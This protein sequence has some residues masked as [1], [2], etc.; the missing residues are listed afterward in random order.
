MVRRLLHFVALGALTMTGKRHRPPLQHRVM[1]RPDAPTPLEAQGALAPILLRTA[2]ALVA[3]KEG[4]APSCP[5][6]PIYRSP[7]GRTHPYICARGGSFRTRR[8]PRHS[9]A[10]QRQVVG[11]L[12]QQHPAPATPFQPLQ[13]P[14]S[15]SQSASS[16]PFQSPEPPP[17]AVPLP[18]LY[19]HPQPEAPPPVA[20]P[21]A[22][23][24]LPPAPSAPPPGVPPVPP[25]HPPPQSRTGLAVSTPLPLQ[26]TGP[27]VPLDCALC[28]QHPLVP[29][30][31]LPAAR[32]GF[33]SHSPS[34][35]LPACPVVPIFCSRLP[36]FSNG[37]PRSF[38]PAFPL[39]P[40]HQP[41]PGL[42]RGYLN[43]DEV[44]RTPRDPDV[45]WWAVS[46]PSCP[47]KGVWGQSRPGEAAYRT[48]GDRLSQLDEDQ[49]GRVREA[50]AGALWEL[51]HLPLEP[52]DPLLD[53]GPGAAAF[54]RVATAAEVSP[55]GIV[56]A[57]ASLLQW[58][59]R[60]VNQV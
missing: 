43:D 3:H 53:D 28:R 16:L 41:M 5:R 8:P 40:Q 31:R 48:R 60:R 27:P 15:L 18:H 6:D 12:L 46:W 1:G 50:V 29:G 13:L 49:Q 35:L 2:A 17:A 9:P 52:E 47:R 19:S 37:F 21:L 45:D 42:S 30:S 10:V 20:V 51:L 34:P 11:P 32:F 4:A 23:P 36:S 38:C 54:R 22:A 25:P 14:P 59:G 24:S 33:V 26:T 55:L 58:L 44:P 56:P 57:V 7:R 39:F